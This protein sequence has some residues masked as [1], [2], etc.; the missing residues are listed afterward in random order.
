[1]AEDHWATTN[2]YD[3]ITIQNSLSLICIWTE[4]IIYGPYFKKIKLVNG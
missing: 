3:M 4:N 2:L 1:M